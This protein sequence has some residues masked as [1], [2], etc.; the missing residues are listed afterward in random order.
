MATLWIMTTA[1]MLHARFKYVTGKTNTPT[2]P[3]EWIMSFTPT[4]AR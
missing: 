3:R 4:A 1:S 2:N